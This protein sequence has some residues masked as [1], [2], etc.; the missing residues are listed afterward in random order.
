M[1]GRIAH[2]KFAENFPLTGVVGSATASVV[3]SRS[4]EERDPVAA[5][6]EVFFLYQLLD[7]ERGAQLRAP[8]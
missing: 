8:P 7:T 6:R 4:A 5:E 3:N 2:L 1:S